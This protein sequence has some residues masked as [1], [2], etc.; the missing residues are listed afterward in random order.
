MEKVLKDTQKA[1]EIALGWLSKN[2]D[3]YAEKKE[4]AKDNEGNTIYF[5]KQVWKL[6]EKTDIY[7]DDS[8]PD[9][10][11]QHE[12]T[13]TAN[14]DG[15]RGSPIEYIIATEMIPEREVT[16]Q[17]VFNTIIRSLVYPELLPDMPENANSPEFTPLEAMKLSFA[18]LGKKYEKK[19]PTLPNSICFLDYTFRFKPTIDKMLKEHKLP[20][21]TSFSFEMCHNCCVCGKE[22]EPAAKKTNKKCSKCGYSY[23]CSIDCQKKD[24]AEHKPL[25]DQL[26]QRVSLLAPLKDLPFFPWIS[27]AS[28]FP[29]ALFQEAYD[30]H[31]VGYWKVMCSICCRPDGPKLEPF[32]KDPSNKVHGLPENH[33]P[34]NTSL[35]KIQVIK[36][37]KD[38]Y[39]ARKI[40][41]ES[42]AAIILAYPLTVFHILTNVWVGAE[43]LLKN[44]DGA[45][46]Y[47]HYVGPEKELALVPLFQELVH[48]LPNVQLIMDW[49]GPSVPKY[50]SNTSITFKGSEGN[51]GSLLINFKSSTY[52]KV[53]K[54]FHAP[55][56]VIALNFGSPRGP[57]WLPAFK[58]MANMKIPCFF[59]DYEL[60]I[61]DYA[62]HI[63]IKT[64][65]VE[66]KSD[67]EINPF[68][69][70]FRNRTGS[71]ENPFYSNGF[72]CTI[73]NV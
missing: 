70:P 58:L 21:K 23:Y 28:T 61:C 50:L 65:F 19:K 51:T 15:P 67:T 30:V 57:E 46:V 33:M 32:L 66:R 41:F 68:R 40:P 49:V 8:D 48:L 27:E 44:P 73:N 54:E 59:T 3:N 38:Y 29:M 31:H 37:W 9:Q 7:G 56:L 71:L 22:D 5:T 36:N 62:L 45:V 34:P 6:T 25:C 2:R 43:K 10:K 4:G 47:I 35:T 18:K 60:D 69:S 63:F 20:I 17:D 53:A 52:E 16:V 64:L 39:E 13:I 24:W 72:M 12:I 55:D 11:I 26:K 42:I 14:V 1:T